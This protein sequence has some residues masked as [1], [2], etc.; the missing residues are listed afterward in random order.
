LLE[1]IERAIKRRL[2]LKEKKK[3]IKNN[4]KSKR[5]GGK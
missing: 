5:L 1:K 3:K 2:S 4:K